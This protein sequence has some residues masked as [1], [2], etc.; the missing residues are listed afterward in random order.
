MRTVSVTLAFAVVCALNGASAQDKVRK[1]ELSNTIDHIL[2]GKWSGLKGGAAPVAEDGEFLRR[3]SLDLRGHPPGLTELRAFIAET[4]ANKRL[5]KIDEYLE[6]D[7]YATQMGHWLNNVLFFENCNDLY[8]QPGKNFSYKTRKR[9]EKDF[10]G[11][12]KNHAQKD[13]PVVNV[14]KELLE[15][16]GSTEKNPLVLYKLSM[17]DGEPA[18]LE[19]ADRLSR[20]W[21]GVKIS[22]AKCHDHPFDNWTQE[23]FYGMAGFF[24]RHKLKLIGGAKDNECDEVEMYEDA[25]AMPLTMPE[26][27]KVLKARF[28]YGGDAAK[29]DPYMTALAFFM[30]RRDHNMLA[31]NFANRLWAWLMGRGLYHP[32]DDFNKK[33]KAT[34]PE[35]L[36]N[37][38]REFA[39]NKY[40]IKFL[41]RAIC[42]SKSY[43]RGSQREVT[44]DVKDFARATI[45]QQTT[46][47]LFNSILVASKG[48]EALDKGEGQQMWGYW[49]S[50]MNLVFG[51]GIA[52]SEISFVPPN[53]RTM[54]LIRNSDQVRNIV[55]GLATDACTAPGE[56]AEKID[57][58]MLRILC[59]PA[60]DGEKERWT[61][62]L[63]DHDSSE[64]YEDLVWTLFNSTEFVTRH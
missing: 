60:T 28:I 29:A 42:A 17:Y 52:W 40:S 10:R 35:L 14:L 64:G 26:T 20:A 54:L 7:A 45:R 46:A 39:A 56:K 19:F 27:N 62:W 34:I 59:R 2:E 43:Q 38:A 48:A 15:S 36:D 21:L 57:T 32:V 11:Y 5:A 3:L 47:Q 51:P 44:G 9:L 58:L 24:S 33:N 8:I 31:R 53:A 25:Q 23:D 37:M 61:K 18:H 16:S 1:P 4:D 22:C 50:Q 49:T 30:A 55:R 41:V 63:T 6:S 12:L 13:T